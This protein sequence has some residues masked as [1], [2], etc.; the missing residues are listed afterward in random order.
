MSGWLYILD[1][2]VHRN[3]AS[4]V[5]KL[6]IETLQGLQLAPL[7]VKQGANGCSAACVD[8]GC[9]VAILLNSLLHVVWSLAW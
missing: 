1:L 4:S 5:R 2:L 8:F 7:S 6:H 3:K 9:Q